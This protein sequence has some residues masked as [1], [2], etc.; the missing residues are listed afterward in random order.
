MES[1]PTNLTIGQMLAWLKMV[2]RPNL[3]EL[4]SA[5]QMSNATYLKVE[6]QEREMSFLMALRICKFYNLDLHQLIAMLSDEELARLEFSV[7][8]AQA[9]RIRWKA[10]K[11]AAGKEA[12]IVDMSKSKG[13]DGAKR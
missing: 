4:Y 12:K 6:R 3:P 10:E 13:M 1:F 8:D 5:L 2:F 7:S 9:K 11:Q